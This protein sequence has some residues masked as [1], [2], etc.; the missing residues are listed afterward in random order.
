MPL[1]GKGEGRGF[2]TFAQNSETTDYL[3]MAYVQA[4][5]IKATQTI[6]NYAV[7]V[8]QPTLDQVT[9]KHK[10]VFDHIILLP[11]DDAKDDSWKLRNEWKAF[12]LTPFYET[13]K[14]ESDI[15]FPT[16]VDHW[17]PALQKHE[18]IMTSTVTDYEGNPATSRA[19]RQLFD[20]NNLPDLYSGLMYFRFSK[21]AAEFFKMARTIYTN[22]EAFRDQILIKCYDKNPT[23]D[24]VFAIAAL[25][26]NKEACYNPALGYPTFAHMKGSINGWGINVDWMEKLYAQFNDVGNLTVGFRR[27]TSPFHYFQK[28]FI[29]PEIVTYYE[30]L[31]ERNRAS[32]T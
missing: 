15:L 28:H 19:Y 26:T 2:I 31:Y 11:E 17:W 27:Q 32:T 14:V 18:L 10:K 22:W 1:N 3:T 13:I 20:E 8:D 5:N 6:N 12:N 30:E 4:L 29:T 24:V 16:S 21:F 23:T 9:D 25:L 7:I